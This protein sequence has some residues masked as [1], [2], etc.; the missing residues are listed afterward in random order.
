MRKIL[1]GA[2]VVVVL[3]SFAG[4][5]G[6]Q[7]AIPKDKI[8]ADLSP[9]LKGLVEGLYAED[10][11]KRAEAAMKLG[12]LEEKAKP[13]VP[14][15][16]ALLADDKGVELKIPGADIASSTSPGIEAAVALGRIDRKSVV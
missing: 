13:A 14:F 8:P 12:E 7:P 3:A 2:L 6:A 15:L 11:A 5:A 10:V 16:V 9:D 4:W 1:S